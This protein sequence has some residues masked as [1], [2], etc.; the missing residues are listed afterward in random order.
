[1]VGPSHR[2]RLF[3]FLIG[4]TWPIIQY[5]T[6]ITFLG[7]RGRRLYPYTLQM[8]ILEAVIGKNVSVNLIFL[9][10]WF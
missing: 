8:I 10:V 7:K 4:G 3:Y 9:R 1:M 2:Y 5:G 6:I